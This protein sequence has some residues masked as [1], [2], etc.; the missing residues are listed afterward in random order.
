MRVVAAKTADGCYSSAP[1]ALVKSEAG[2]LSALWQCSEEQE[3][4][5]RVL[6]E[7]E[8]Q[9]DGLVDLQVEEVAWASAS[10]SVSTAASSDGF[11]C[12]H[13]RMLPAK[14]VEVVTVFLRCIELIGRLP[15]Q[16]MVLLSVMIPKSSAGFRAL[17]I[18][19]FLYRVWAKA[20]RYQLRSWERKH[21]QKWFS[22][23][24]GN[25]CVEAIWWQAVEVE[26]YASSG[27]AVAAFMWDLSNYYEHFSRPLL[28]ERAIKMGFPRN[29]LRVAMAMHTTKRV[30]SMA[31]LIEAVGFP[32]KG[33][34][35]GGAFATHLVV[36]YCA[37]QFATFV[38][39]HPN[40]TLNVQI[41]DV[42]VMS[43]A[44]NDNIVVP[45]LSEAADSMVTLIDA[46]LK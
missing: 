43:A 32:K 33:I 4:E 20:R 18:Y 42:Q 13:I 44:P 30:V 1:Q 36:A 5:A 35:A 31:G 10:F 26:R 25:S 21:R 3:L 37:E 27:G 45:D 11:H 2:R 8:D 39:T 7:V 41:D 6:S 24:S 46:G 22:W 17:G 12:R 9:Q 38:E 34:V 23:A 16:L 28:I 14:A 40:V 15:T 19:P 29:I